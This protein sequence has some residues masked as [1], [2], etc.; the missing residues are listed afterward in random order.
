MGLVIPNTDISVRAG[1][2]PIWKGHFGQCARTTDPGTVLWFTGIGA[3][4]MSLWAVVEAT[5]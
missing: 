1:C 4:K 5:S 3:F 2:E